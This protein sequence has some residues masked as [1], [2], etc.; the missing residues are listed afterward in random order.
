MFTT[1]KPHSFQSSSNS[2]ATRPARTPSHPPISYPL[3]SNSHASQSSISVAST[4][5][6]NAR[7]SCQNL[8]HWLS[9]HS[10]QSSVSSTKPASKDAEKK[11][12]PSIELVC[13][14]RSGVLGTGATVVKT[15]QDALRD[16]RVRTTFDGK[17][18]EL[19]L[20]LP[21]TASP[22]GSIHSRHSGSSQSS[23]RKAGSVKDAPLQDFMS[24]IESHSP[25][26]PLAPLPQEEEKQP[27]ATFTPPNPARSSTQP[28]RPTREL[29]PP[30][31]PSIA[32][33]QR[34]SSSTKS[35][36]EVD[37]SPESVPPLP[38]PAAA[39]PK[40]PPFKAIL[41][42][43][44]PRTVVDRAQTIVTLET[45]TTTYKTTFE[46]LTSRPSHLATYLVSLLER[47]PRISAA[48]SV[49]STD[50]SD[51]Y[52]DHGNSLKS[53]FRSRSPTNIRIFLDRSSAP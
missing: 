40:V 25:P 38:K 27:D 34:S 41:M 33:S 5:S 17:S 31:S 44:V 28:P 47:S 12:R 24:A 29:P 49:Y 16:S 39:T 32:P 13:N 26:V 30:P 21:R 36:P 19:N 8:M 51:E 18:Q 6:Q 42:S 2:N 11:P 7:S 23:S 22:P 35:K 1:A 15:P 37:E 48:S 46:T 53:G 50:S 9:R 10:T 45:C 3:G 4:S 14:A 43:D 52:S 20:N